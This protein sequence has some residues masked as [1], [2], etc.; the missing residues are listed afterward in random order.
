MQI[1]AGPTSLFFRKLHGCGN[2]FVVLRNPGIASQY[3][4]TMARN[5]CSLHYGI[6]SDGLMVLEDFYGLEQN[7]PVSMFNPDGSSMG[8]C[9]NG[10]RCLTRFLALENLRGLHSFH[11]T[12]SVE[13]R[14]IT[15]STENAG[16]LVTV[17]MGLPSFAPVDIGL[18]LQSE[19][20]DSPL[21]ASGH[22]YRASAVSMGNPHCVIVV[23]DLS[24]VDIRHIGPILENS[25][26]FQNRTN[27][28]FVQVISKNEISILIWER[29][30]GVTLA[31]GTGA[32]AATVTCIKLGLIEE[33]PQV[34]LPGGK[35][36]VKWSGGAASHVFLTGPAVEVFSGFVKLSEIR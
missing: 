4:P 9:G 28:E 24:S 1:P 3:W 34:L 6:G 27:V 17:D 30:A 16:E 21:E 29:G 11:V 14:E 35:L 10:I 31:C 22:C 20:I 15:C 36:D 23:P 32:C 18:D 33:H 26:V 8:M 13:G 5:L 25:P 2:D 12:F 19:F 7:V